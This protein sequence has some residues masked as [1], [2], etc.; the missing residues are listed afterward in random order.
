M[1]V[2]LA[3]TGSACSTASDDAA[4]RGTLAQGDATVPESGPDFVRN[5]PV[6]VTGAPIESDSNEPAAT[7]DPPAPGSDRATEITAAP[8]IAAV[9]DTGVPGIDSTDAFC[10]SWSEFAGSFRS[11]GLASAFRESTDAAALELIASPAV[12]SAASELSAT[13]P[14]EL[15]V[16]RDAFIEEFVG[17]FGSR[18]ARAS[19]VLRAAGATEAQLR[20]IGERWLD[21]L[22]DVGADDPTIEV[23]IADLLSA[24]LLDGAVADFSAEVPPIVADPS[25][26]TDTSIPATE[27]YLAATCPDGGVLL[28]NDDI[29]G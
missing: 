29:G 13:L 10:R 9:P 5:D 2:V 12:V 7:T 25:L 21:V 27:A 3:L 11:L 22:A 14:L 6:V 19:G 17:R 15:E 28:G 4:A 24:D 26:T 8:T 16:E 23:D 1:S 18:A 20:S